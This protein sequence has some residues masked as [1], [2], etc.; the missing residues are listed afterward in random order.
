V[1]V[2]VDAQVVA[3][4]VAAVAAVVGVPL[5]GFFSHRSA[6]ATVRRGGQQ[7]QFSEVL[8]K[9]IEIYP[10]LWSIHI[11]YETNWELDR[12]PKTGG[13]AREYLDAL[14]DLNVEGGVFFSQAL[15]E[16][17]FQLRAQLDAAAQ[18]MPADAL[19]P[20]DRVAAIHDIVYGKA[21]DPG[22]STIEKDDLGSYRPIELQRR[23]ERP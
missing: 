7:S 2:G 9:R 17:F 5:A 11:R 3:A 20:P 12:R 21:G 6:M 1:E 18:Q 14:N 16:K 15:Y 8:R 19:I 4:V 22:M 13:W 10:R 23:R